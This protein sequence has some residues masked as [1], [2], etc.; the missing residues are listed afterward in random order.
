MTY[1]DKPPVYEWFQK[2]SNWLYCH[3]HGALTVAEISID[4]NNHWV[5]YD[6]TGPLTRIICAVKDLQEAKIAVGREFLA[7]ATI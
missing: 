3:S 2:D 5:A 6:L 1:A 7:K 4:A